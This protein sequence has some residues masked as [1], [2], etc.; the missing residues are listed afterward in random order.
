MKWE[1][2]KVGSGGPNRFE[3][4]NSWLFVY[5]YEALTVL[6]RVENI[7]RIF[8]YSVLKNKYFDNWSQQSTQSDDAEKGS[9]ESIAKRRINQAN[10]FAYLGYSTSCPIMYLTSGELVRLI[11]LDAYWDFFKNYFPGTKE[12]MKN[13]LEEIGSIRNSLA[14]FRPMKEEDVEIIKQNSKQVLMKIE[15]NL[16]EMLNCRTIVPTNTKDDWYIQSKTLN[17]EFCKINTLRSKDEKWINL[18]LS[19]SCPI[20]EVQ[21]Y[22]N[23]KTYS[24]LSID[25]I[26]ILRLNPQLVKYITYVTEDVGAVVQEDANTNFSKELNI[27]FAVDVLKE[28][29]QE[30]IKSISVII[31]KI[32]EETDLIK[33]DNLAKGDFV[34][35]AYTSSSLEEDESSQWWRADTKSLKT[36]DIRNIPPEF[37]GD[38]DT[39]F[40]D[41]ISEAHRYPWMATDISSETFPF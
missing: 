9:I 18:Q 1:K 20:I 30:I 36:Q 25:P 41:F 14:H 22:K 37:W 19:Y 33:K 29:A 15:Q 39:M 2:A 38:I 17:S 3:I 7:L 35:T 4:P 21:N 34:L 12:I 6:F 5:Y 27:V 31:K 23:Y 8:V 28:N 11:I 40:Y 16:T 24:L 26:N 13:K 10:N 32:S